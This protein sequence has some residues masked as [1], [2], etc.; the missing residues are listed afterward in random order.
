MIAL[1]TEREPREK[2]LIGVALGLVFVLLLGQFVIKP[3]MN[4]PV[5]QKRVLEQAERDLNVMRDGKLALMGAK[6]Q[7]RQALEVNE[8]QSMITN[9]AGQNGLAITRRQPN[10]DTGLTVWLETV[11]SKLMYQWLDELTGKYEI[12]VLGANLNRN[13]D[14]TV[15]AQLTFKIG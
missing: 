9:S 12:S 6:P 13:D 2:V 11:D 4:Y 15:R 8:A 3:M 10:G 5:A 14:G 7:V 1:W